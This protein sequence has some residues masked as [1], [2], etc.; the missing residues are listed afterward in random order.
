[1]LTGTEV[2]DVTG[3]DVSVIAIDGIHPKTGPIHTLS[4]L[5]AGVAIVAGGL[6]V[7]AGTTTERVA[8]LVG[9]D[10]PVVAGQRTQ[11]GQTP[12]VLAGIAEGAGVTIVTSGGVV[13]M[14]SQE[15]LDAANRQRPGWLEVVKV[16]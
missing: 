2:A 14:G 16:L 5:S 9:A 6:V 4:T 12:A 15:T 7:R 13:V 10:V 1:M 3:A 11:P 8:F